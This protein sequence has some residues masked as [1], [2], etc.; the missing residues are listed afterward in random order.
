MAR[1][2]RHEEEALHKA[3]VGTSR[4]RLSTKIVA[5]NRQELVVVTN[6]LKSTS[7]SIAALGEVR[8]V[9]GVEE[10]GHV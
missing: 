3:G 1:T 7:S 5:V 4:P 2:G 8:G 9:E 6:P 10:Q